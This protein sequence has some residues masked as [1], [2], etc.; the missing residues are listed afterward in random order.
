MS[1]KHIEKFIDISALK[2]EFKKM[3]T[4][5]VT[6]GVVGVFMNHYTGVSLS[7]LFWA[8]VSIT[9]IGIVALYL[10]LRKGEAT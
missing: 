1:L 2:E 9:G 5:F 6:A 3:G 8:S 7:S 10:G 4:N